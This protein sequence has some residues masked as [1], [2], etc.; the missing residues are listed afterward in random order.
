MLPAV[1]VVVVVAVVEV[2]VAEI[3]VAI[4]VVVAVLVVVVV[5]TDESQPFTMHTCLDS[6]NRIRLPSYKGVGSFFL[7]CL[8]STKVPLAEPRSMITRLT[9]RA[10]GLL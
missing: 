2:V 6:P 10:W 1:V 4:V 3:A 9:G 8:P 7:H 5:A